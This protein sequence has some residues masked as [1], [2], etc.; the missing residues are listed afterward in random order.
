[1]IKIPDSV[2]SS[3]QNLDFVVKTFCRPIGDMAVFKGIQYFFGP[4]PVGG[5]TLFEFGN[6]RL[7]SCRNP[8]EEF[9]TLLRILWILT[10]A[11]KPFL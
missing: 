6:L 5:G 4:M 2:G 1:M 3:F 7:F 9:L 8:V 10:D 11:V